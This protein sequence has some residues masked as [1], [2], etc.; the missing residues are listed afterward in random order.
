MIQY[1]YVSGMTWKF[2]TKS[3]VQ[4]AHYRGNRAV[5]QKGSEGAPTMVDIGSIPA[6]K[7]PVFDVIPHSRFEPTSYRTGV[8]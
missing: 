1:L 5:E 2:K 4:F 8:K 7:Y 3:P 6:S